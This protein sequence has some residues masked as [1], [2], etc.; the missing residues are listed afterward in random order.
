MGW[1]PVFRHTVGYTMNY[2]HFKKYIKENV[3][4]SSI[5]FHLIYTRKQDISA[6]S[7]LFTKPCTVCHVQWKKYFHPASGNCWLAVMQHH[8]L[9]AEYEL[10][11][12]VVL[13]PWLEQPESS[14][15]ATVPRETFPCLVRYCLAL[16]LAHNHYSLQ[17]TSMEE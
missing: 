9:T 13:S 15:G 1:P 5:I 3:S 16:T 17:H 6:N 8:A 11:M 4:I 12:S 2:S 10:L 7:H 14:M